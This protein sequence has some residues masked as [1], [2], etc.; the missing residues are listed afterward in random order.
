MADRKARRDFNIQYSIPLMYYFLNLASNDSANCS[1]SYEDVFSTCPPNDH[2]IQDFKERMGIDIRTLSWEYNKD[3]ITDIISK[4]F[5]PLLKKIATMFFAHSCDI[6]LLSGRPA[7]LPAIRNIFLKYYAVS[8]N[9]LITLNNYYVGDW[10]PFD[11][12][13]GFIKNPKTIV[14][15][16]GVVG[17]YASD[18]SRLDKFAINL[19][20]LKT[21][22]KST[23]NYIEA[24]R[25]GKP[26]DYVIT[27]D[28]NQGDITISKLPCSLKVR[29]FGLAS[30]PSRDLYSVDFN[31]LKLT[32]KI[33]TKANANGENISDAAIQARVNNEVDALQMRMPFTITIEKDIE[34][35]ENLSIVS[36]TDRNGAELSDSCIEIHIQSLGVDENGGG[37]QY[38]LDS[39]A[40]NF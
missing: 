39:G 10:Y 32:S 11:E 12:N 3:F 1:V 38:W 14:A 13:T 7:S 26:I 35:K 28:K 21:N 30:Y 23:V 9:R 6:I 31:R 4:E 24:S 17:Y 34:D 2:V 18:F 8:P 20:K 36:I 27:P 40:F 19:E 5:E 16:G 33:R 37:E 29:Q 25:D 15:M 22:L